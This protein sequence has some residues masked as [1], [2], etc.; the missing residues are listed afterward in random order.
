MFISFVS[1]YHVTRNGIRQNCSDIQKFLT[2]M[3]I[4]FICTAHKSYVIAYFYSF[5]FET[6]CCAREHF[7]I[8]FKRKQ[9]QDGIKCINTEYPLP[10]YEN[11][12]YATTCIPKFSY[13]GNINIPFTI[14]TLDKTRF[15]TSIEVVIFYLVMFG[16][17]NVFTL[18][19]IFIICILLYLYI[20]IIPAHI[21]QKVCPFPADKLNV[22]TYNMY[23]T[24]Y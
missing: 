11:I 20:T 3:Y 8:I 5:E 10:Q 22:P 17:S 2:Y 15:S 18:V 7:L 13:E 14:L 6:F 4:S 19:Y 16:G 23:N 12:A 21:L 24:S 1:F 9:H